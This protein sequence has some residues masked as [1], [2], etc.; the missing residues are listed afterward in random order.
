MEPMPEISGVALEQNNAANEVRN[1]LHRTNLS[2]S[3]MVA[4]ADT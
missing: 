2:Q 3:T 1:D 4:S